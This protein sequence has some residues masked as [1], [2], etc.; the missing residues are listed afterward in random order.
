MD[1]STVKNSKDGFKVPEDYFENFTDRL[2]DSV[3]LRALG[4]KK[5]D[6]FKVPEGYFE[7]VYASVAQRIALDNEKEHRFFRLRKMPTINS[8]LLAIAASVIILIGSAVYFNSL[9]ER[10][11]LRIGSDRPTATFA[12]E[13][14]LET[15]DESTLGDALATLPQVVKTEST[16]SIV[17]YLIDN[18]I[19][20]NLLTD[21][22]NS[23]VE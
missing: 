3:R 19:D 7:G 11:K 1:N 13:Q 9:A 5:V 8:R 6:G 15:I 10:G 18:R 17:N 14:V 4:A 22:L 12:D 20:V 23:N 2:A 16:D 21:E